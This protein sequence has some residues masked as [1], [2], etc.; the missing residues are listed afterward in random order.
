MASNIDTTQPPALNP[1]TAALR[2]NMAAA[3]A[4]IEALQALLASDLNALKPTGLDQT[5]E[6]QQYCNDTTKGKVFADFSQGDFII[7]GD[8]TI[9]PRFNASEEWGYGYGLN[10]RGIAPEATRLIDARATKTTPVILITDPTGVGID[11][12]GNRRQ[13]QSLLS[14]FSLLSANTAGTP[15]PLGTLS[16]VGLMS[17]AVVGTG[18][19]ANVLHSSQIERVR[20]SGYDYPLSLDDCTQIEISHCRFTEFLTAIRVGGNADLWDINFCGFGSELFGS[21]YRNNSVCIHMNWTA[22]VIPAGS[23]NLFTVDNA[24]VMKV[25]D[26]IKTT[27]TSR[28][29]FIRRAYL[30][31]VLR[32]FYAA[33]GAGVSTTN[34]VVFEACHFSTMNANDSAS[35]LKG[36]AGFSSK[37]QFGDADASSTSTS[38][39][40]VPHLTLRHCT[41]DGTPANAL[42][43]FTNRDGN[44]QWDKNDIPPSLTY[45]HLRCLR[46]G[47]ERYVTA[48]NYQGTPV[49]GRWSYGRNQSSGLAVLEGDPVV[50]QATIAAAGTYNIDH[51]NGSQ[52]ELTLP[53]GD[54]TIDVAAYVAGP[55]SPT[56]GSGVELDVVLI[57]PATVTGSRTITWG[58]RLS[59]PA[60]TLSFSAADQGKRAT[61]KIRSFKESGN[62][63]RI[64][65]RDPVFV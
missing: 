43:T 29:I 19:G 31:N 55:P 54:C 11:P 44:I 1:T 42:V 59:M 46:D 32:Y 37:I 58:A 14:G 10:L 26:F 34:P 6:I 7:T 57:A 9:H 63:M 27:A 22:G 13:I 47:W 30:E 41:G 39:G 56:M 25:G 8:I 36:N 23:A 33:P 51:V 5:A 60:A 20:F 53:D 16:G 62:V 64:I 18:Y 12:D 35:A 24:W 21:T 45:G 52:F 15:N 17:K 28:P 3:K 38:A 2:A 50:K 49:W 40:P 61:F 48:G 4:E 65:S